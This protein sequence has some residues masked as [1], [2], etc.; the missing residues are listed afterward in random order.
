M[1]TLNMRMSAPRR[2]A[3][4]LVGLGILFAASGT[5]YTVDEKERGVILRNGALQGVAEPGLGFKIPFIDSVR[6][7]SVQNHTTAYDKLQAYSRDQQTAE[8]R[9]SVS[10]HVLPSDVAHVYTAYGDLDALVGRLISRQVPTQV[11]NVFGQYTAIAAVQ[12]RGKFVADVAAAIKSSISGPVVID[13]V[14]VENI[15]F[16]DAYERSIED[17]MKAEI[18]IKTREQN[19]ATEEVQAKIKVTQAKAEAD[20]ALAKARAEAEATRLKGQAEADAIK[21]RAEALASNQN[22]IELTKAERWDGKLPDTVL[23]NTALPFIDAVK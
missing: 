23:P 22:L 19:L 7:I 10:W 18:E 14:Q 13:G 16:S 17:R 15:D 2:I 21:A 8:L 20:A 12:N 9:V 11:E 1:D 6:M 3:P 4:L 5:W